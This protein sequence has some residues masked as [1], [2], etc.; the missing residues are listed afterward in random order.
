MDFSHCSWYLPCHKCFTWIKKSHPFGTTQW[1]L[2]NLIKSTERE[3]NQLKIWNVQNDKRR[4]TSTWTFVIEQNS[5]GSK[6]IVGFSIIY[7]NPE[8]IHFGCPCW[9]RIRVELGYKCTG[10]YQCMIG[11]LWVNKLGLFHHTIWL[12]SYLV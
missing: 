12:C 7:N 9:Q 2:G 4:C 5:I 10:I 6:H 3:K 1:T 11:T 8:S